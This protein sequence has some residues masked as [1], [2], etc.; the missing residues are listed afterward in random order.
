MG[1]TGDKIC[2][3]C[4]GSGFL[5]NRDATDEI[6]LPIDINNPDSQMVDATKLAYWI[7]L[8]EVTWNK[9]RD[10][11]KVL[12]HLI[13]ETIW[14]TKEQTNGNDTATGR[15][16]DN[17]PKIN[18]LNDYSD[19]A[20]WIEWQSSEWIIRFYD[21]TT[22]ESRASINLGRFY[23]I[24]SPDII[25]KKYLENKASG[26]PN[27]IL[28]F[29]LKEVVTTKWKND[30]ERLG[31]EYKKIAIEPYPHNTLKEIYEVFGAEE[32][33]KKTEFQKWWSQLT[34]ADKL[35]DEKTL[36][37]NLENHLKKVYDSS[38]KNVPTI[39]EG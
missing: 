7:G 21:Q 2:E 8:D 6:I 31:I 25:V 18:R 3:S 15:F 19:M 30:P 17:Q 4:G 10:E 9:Y 34:T 1:K 11:L 38:S 22:K 16:I 23:I 13:Y 32:A 5:V 12:E 33:K 26:A 14:G 29:N 28:D 39:Q 27:S 35:K 24:E 37:N 20:E 36:R